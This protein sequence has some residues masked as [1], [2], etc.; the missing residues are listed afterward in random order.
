M[1]GCH[2]TQQSGCWCFQRDAVDSTPK[3]WQNEWSQEK[4]APSRAH[5]S[6]LSCCVLGWRQDAKQ[7]HLVAKL[8]KN[9]GW[10]M[11][12]EIRESHY[13]LTAKN[14]A[15]VKPGMIFNVSI[16]GA[17]SP[18]CA[19]FDIRTGEYCRWGHND[20]DAG[21]L[22]WMKRLLPGHQYARGN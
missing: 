14:T 2:V 15:T 17:P 12:T 18:P 13:Q 16:G 6:L 19:C 21:A 22:M 7:G 9:I 4:R 3:T 11:G 8:P 1:R 10:S 5:P 20:V